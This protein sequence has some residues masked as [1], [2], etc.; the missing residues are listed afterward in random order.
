[1]PENDVS[2]LDADLA[3]LSATAREAGRIALG[4]FGRDCQVWMKN[5][6]KSP[7]SEADLAVDAYLKHTLLQARPDYGWISEESADERETRP[8]HRSFI[9][10][11]IDGTRGFLNGSSQWCISIAIIEGNSPICGVVECPI[12]QEHYHA[13]RKIPAKLNDAPLLQ[14]AH[15]PE[16]SK[17]RLSCQAAIARELPP[18]LL[19]RLELTPYIPSLAYRLVLVAK[20]EIDLVLVRPGSHDWDIAAADIILRQTGHC[21]A[22]LQSVPVSYGHTPFRHDILLAGHENHKEEVIPYL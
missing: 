7:V 12:A 13:H 15:H 2:S 11:P 1:L 10:D 5:G 21:L 20:G 3:L 17:I 18:H 8:Y 19:Q 22:T 6:D 4:F 9:V 16:I 14:P